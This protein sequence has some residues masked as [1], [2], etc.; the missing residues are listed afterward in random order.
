MYTS[1]LYLIYFYIKQYYFSLNL[2]VK[3]DS[4]VLNF[5]LC[6]IITLI[7][8]LFYLPELLFWYLILGV[9]FPLSPSQTYPWGAQEVFPVL[10]SGINPQCLED[11]MLWQVL[12]CIWEQ[13]RQESYNCIS[14]ITLSLK[15]LRSALLFMQ[16]KHFSFI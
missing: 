1:I 8:E 14:S 16:L 9:C 5:I 3:I 4:Q 13:A 7:P 2:L 11:Y 10:C 15:L 6:I 12:N